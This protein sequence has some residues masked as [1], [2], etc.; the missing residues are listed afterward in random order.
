MEKIVESQQTWHYYCL[1]HMVG[2][3]CVHT[4]TPNK[5]FHAVLCTFILNNVDTLTSAGAL[6]LI[7]CFVFIA[8]LIKE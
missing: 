7:V 6:F 1:A 3:P 5:S 2:D 8:T 4:H